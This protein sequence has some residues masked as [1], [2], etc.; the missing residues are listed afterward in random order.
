[1]ASPGRRGAPVTDRVRR[2][3]GGAG[4]GSRWFSVPQS[5]AAAANRSVRGRAI[6]ETQKFQ[7][8]ANRLK[9]DRWIAP[10]LAGGTF[11]VAVGGLVTGVLSLMKL[12]G[13]G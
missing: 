1:M 11:I 5:R 7:A 3:D 12:S 8:E 4:R 9:A 13:H 2:V 6:A 10:F